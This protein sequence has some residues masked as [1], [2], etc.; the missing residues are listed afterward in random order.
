MSSRWRG[1]HA[2]HL[3]EGNQD[4]R[5]RLREGSRRFRSEVAQTGGLRCEKRR[6]G[7]RRRLM[8]KDAAG[9]R[10]AALRGKL[11]MQA[12]AG[13]K[14]TLPKPER[15]VSRR[16]TTDSAE[17]AAAS[18]RSRFSASCGG[19]L[20]G[21]S[22]GPG[23]GPAR[24]PMAS[25]QR[26]PHR[27]NERRE[28]VIGRV[29]PGGRGLHGRAL[30][31][32][33]NATVRN[34]VPSAIRQEEIPGACASPGGDFRRRRCVVEVNAFLASGRSTSRHLEHAFRLMPDMPR[35]K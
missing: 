10:P 18:Q 35:T 16:R 26:R 13:R 19:F 27:Q 24:P 22:R 33:A 23:H 21:R 31:A 1:E 3:R 8:R 34:A 32:G 20:E 12:A 4:T 14:R 2:R 5:A 28:H 25:S 7:I 17:R 30:A 9:A 11:V 6:N 29:L 15:P